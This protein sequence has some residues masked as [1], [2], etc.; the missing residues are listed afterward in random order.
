MA[1]T[2]PKLTKN[3]SYGIDLFVI[4]AGVKASLVQ[5]FDDTNNKKV[6]QRSICCF[7]IDAY[8]LAVFADHR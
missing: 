3:T 6:H 8:I 4:S 7:C 5:K 1:S 2:E